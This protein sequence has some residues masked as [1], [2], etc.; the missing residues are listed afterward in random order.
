MTAG[1]Y[2]A[3]SAVANA[4]GIAAYVAAQIAL[5]T[6]GNGVSY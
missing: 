5:I 2:D 6:D 4:G 3:N 1:T